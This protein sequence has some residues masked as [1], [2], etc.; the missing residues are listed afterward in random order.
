M[1]SLGALAVLLL[2]TSGCT[3][4]K[5]YRVCEFNGTVD[6]R[7]FDAFKKDTLGL[8]EVVSDRNPSISRVY[9][10]LN[11]K[12]VIVHASDSIH[13]GIEQSWPALACLGQYSDSIGRGKYESC[14]KYV[15]AYPSQLVQWPTEDQV[16]V[17]CSEEGDARCEGVAPED[18]DAVLYCGV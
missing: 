15:S 10:T 4:T 13:K 8:F 16:L 17:T 1:K 6:D 11:R 18:V 14:V 3:S 7:V 12:F 2:I 9:F 5:S